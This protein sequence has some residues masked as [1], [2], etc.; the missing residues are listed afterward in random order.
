MRF[1]LSSTALGS[2]LNMISKVISS[3]NALPILDCILFEVSNGKMNVTASDSDNVMKTSVALDAQEGEGEFCIPNRTILNALKE[4]PEQPLT[5]DVDTQSFAVKLLYQNGIYNFTAQS[6]EDY[7]RTQKINDNSS[8]ITLDANV[9]L[10]NINRTLFATANNELRP[11]M[12]GIYFDQSTDD[13]TIVATDGHKLVKNQLYTIKSEIVTNFILPKKPSTLLK[14]TLTKEDGD[15]Q[16]KFDNNHAEIAYGETILD[17]R[18]IDGNYPNYKSVIPAN[19]P[20]E[21]TIDRRAFISAVR[22]VLPFASESSLLVRLHFENSKM[23]ISSEDLDF[24]TA[25]KEQMTCDYNGAPLTMGFKGSTLLE[26]LNSLTCDQI[27]MKLA[28]PSR[29]C[30]I[31]PMEQPENTDITMLLMPMMLND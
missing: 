28:D 12:N 4:L 1:T 11:V 29:A 7:P 19:N 21:A 18:L 9:L 24:S 15:V 3:K 13:L 8:T 22:R 31:I 27:V 16:I 14:N 25:A 10:D 20:N 23:E 2:K 30:V 5:F 6:A 26:T 17:C